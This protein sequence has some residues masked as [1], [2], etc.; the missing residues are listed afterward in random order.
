MLIEVAAS[1]SAAI[2]AVHICVITVEVIA[3]H[4]VEWLVVVVVAVICTVTFT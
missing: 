1:V 4:V 3:R 2:V